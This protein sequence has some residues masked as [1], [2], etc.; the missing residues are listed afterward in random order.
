MVQLFTACFCRHVA[1]LVT[2]GSLPYGS[3]SSPR[4]MRYA[5][6]SSLS[7]DWAAFAALH[8]VPHS[9][10]RLVAE[11][12]PFWRTRL[13][14]KE[15]RVCPSRPRSL[16]GPSGRSSGFLPVEGRLHRTA[17]VV[18]G[19][20]LSRY[21]ALKGIEVS[22]GDEPHPLSPVVS[23]LYRVSIPGKLAPPSR[24]PLVTTTDLRLSHVRPR[25]GRREIKEPPFCPGVGDSRVSGHHGRLRGALPAPARSIT[26]GRSLPEPRL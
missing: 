7:P 1:G 23:R 18:L 26:I 4:W 17:P 21:P 20:P 15:S 16:G 2:A 13:G 10:L 14:I 8:L 22:C 12:S 11:A 24:V 5:M 3:R 6:L 9:G 25:E 19:E